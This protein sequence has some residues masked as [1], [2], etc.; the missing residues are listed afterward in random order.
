MT[1]GVLCKPYGNDG[2]F[3]VNR[4]VVWDAQEE[5]AKGELDLE[6]REV[7]ILPV[8][9]RYFREKVW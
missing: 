3:T 5:G 1:F 7:L 6:P 2:S 4:P 9:S 8:I